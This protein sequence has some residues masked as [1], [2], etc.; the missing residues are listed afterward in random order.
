MVFW[1]VHIFD[2][3]EKI[4]AINYTYAIAAGA[5]EWE[6]DT[7]KKLESLPHSQNSHVIDCL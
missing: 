2:P 7:P 3:R 6:A 4:P 1:H 5:E